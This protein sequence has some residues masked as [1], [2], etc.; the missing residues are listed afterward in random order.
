[1][2]SVEIVDENGLIYSVIEEHEIKVPTKK[3]RN[4]S[5]RKALYIAPNLEQIRM[6]NS[7]IE[8]PQLGLRDKSIFSRRFKV[9]LTSKKTNKMLDLNLRFTQENENKKALDKTYLPTKEFLPRHASANPDEYSWVTAGPGYDL[10]LMLAVES[11]Y[12]GEGVQGAVED[13]TTEEYDKLP[14]KIK[15][16]P[17]PDKQGGEKTSPKQAQGM[18]DSPMQKRM[19]GY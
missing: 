4:K 15:L 16:T 12:D 5:G 1:M 13:K 19:K 18:K 17:P 3:T 6:S 14:P 11:K 9:R 8:N 7:D 2:L 10:A